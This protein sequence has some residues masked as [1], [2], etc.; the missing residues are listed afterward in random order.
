MFIFIIKHNKAQD[1]LIKN[2]NAKL[3]DLIIIL[4][5]TYY[6]EIKGEKIYLLKEINTHDIYKTNDFWKDIIIKKIETEFKSF[7]V[8]SKTLTKEKKEKIITTQ[9]INY[10]CFMM[11]F[12]F[13]KSNMS[14]V[15]NQIFDKYKCSEFSREQVLSFI[16]KI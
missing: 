5:L 2:N 14:E 3:G 6:K 16:S 8:S 4:S 9:L 13:I 12:N 10:S 1:I 7:L 11:R 15:F